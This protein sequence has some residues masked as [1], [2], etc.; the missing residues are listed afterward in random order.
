LDRLILAL[1]ALAKKFGL[2]GDR[3]AW[4]WNTTRRTWQENKAQGENKFRATQGDHKM[5]PGCRDLVPR[6]AVKC[7][8]CDEP[9]RKIAGPGYGRAL[10]NMIPGGVSA[11]SLIALANGALFLLTLM[12]SIQK[13]EGASLFGLDGRVL[14][15]FGAAHPYFVLQEGEWW[16]L[17]TAMFLHGGL[18]HIGF[19][20]MAL[21]RLGPFV[22]A[23]FGASR[24]WVIY[25]CGGVVGNLAAVIYGTPV[26]GASGAILAFVG[27][28]FAYGARLKTRGGKFL[29][30]RMFEI[31]IFVGLFSLLPGISLMAHAGGVATGAIFGALLPRG[32]A[33]NRHD[34]PIWQ[35]LQWLLALLC[36]L[37]FWLV[38]RNP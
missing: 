32:E 29:R 10:S 9:L 15:V 11:V 26:V 34:A 3:W 18:L 6:S 31:L 37:S 5:C 4:R 35:V 16:T 33:R 1:C 30:D 14:G 17:I 25:F 7:P 20:T 19:N 28:L 12:W 23:E 36:V 8:Q 13:G 24:T 2:P 38:L 22:E 21:I 27:L